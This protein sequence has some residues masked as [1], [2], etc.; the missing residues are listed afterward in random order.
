MNWLGV[1]VFSVPS[2]LKPFDPT[3]KSF[4]TEC[5]ENAEKAMRQNWR[6]S[7]RQLE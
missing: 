3:G 7:S 4:N 1:S 2:V 6:L 5:T